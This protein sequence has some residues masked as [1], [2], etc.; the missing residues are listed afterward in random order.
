[1]EESKAG[2]FVENA[3]QCKGN[4]RVVESLCAT[5]ALH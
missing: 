1:M 3:R 4:G 2:K 5:V